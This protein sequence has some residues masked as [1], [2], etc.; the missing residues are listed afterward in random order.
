MSSLRKGVGSLRKKLSTYEINEKNIKDAIRDFRRLLI[1]NDVSIDVAEQIS[2]KL[3]KNMMG[4]RAQRFSDLSKLLLEMANPILLDIISPKQ[5]INLI[6]EIVE[7]RK[8]GDVVRSKNPI[9]ILFL[10]INGTGKT[11]SIA[12]LAYRFKKKKLRVIL[13]ASDTFRSG[14]QEQLKSHA[15]TIGVKIITGK[16][17]SDSA[18]V[19]F[20]AI[21][22]AKAKYSDV[23]IVDTSGRMAINKDLMEEMKKIKRITNPDYTILVVD[24]LA[25]NDATKQ[26]VEFHKAITIDGVILAK[27]DADAKGG[28]LISVTYATEGVP[29]LFLG[30][31]QKYD[32]LDL[33]DPELYLKKLLK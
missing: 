20:D 17:G 16:Y 27:M 1:S 25:G 21:A 23:V 5:K 29:I 26:A 8:K 24:A 14:A 15:N 7:K 22:H 18:A 4:K 3:T 11:T 12:K 31:G 6:E 13:A 32:D 19:A 9:V 30:T 10:G 33:F 2:K 28:A